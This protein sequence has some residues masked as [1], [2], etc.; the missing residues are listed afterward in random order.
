[1]VVVM[2]THDYYGGS[3]LAAARAHDENVTNGPQRLVAAHGSSSV[4]YDV[5]T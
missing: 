5:Y 4:L 3:L 2:Y 1:M